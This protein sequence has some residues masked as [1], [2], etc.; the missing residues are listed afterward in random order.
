MKKLTGVPLRE[1][2]ALVPSW[3]THITLHPCFPNHLIFESTK[4]FQVFH[5][6]VPDDAGVCT[7]L[8]NGM[9]D[10]AQT[11]EHYKQILEDDENEC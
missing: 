9:N 5:K 8:P 2:L 6:G 3:C 10:Y 4:R 1:I 7:Q 11:V